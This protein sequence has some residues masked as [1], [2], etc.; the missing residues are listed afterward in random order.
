MESV[1]DGLREIIADFRFGQ[2]AVPL[3]NHIDQD[4]LTGSEVADF[5]LRELLLPVYWEQ[6]YRA[7]LAAG[8]TRFVEVG[9]GDALKKYNR[10]IESEA[11][12]SL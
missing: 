7:L 1:A 8:V 4:F 6:S 11:A 5:L 2:P 9:V 3:L 10:W 12:R